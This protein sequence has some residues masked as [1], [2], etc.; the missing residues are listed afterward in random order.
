MTEQ[1]NFLL[2]EWACEEIDKWVK[3]F[4]EDRKRSAVLYALRIVQE[5]LGWLSEATMQAVGDYLEIPHIMVYE[6]ANFYSM[7]DLK[8]KGKHKL[9]VCTNI[10]CM[11]RG[12][13]AIADHLQQKLGIGF[14]QTTKDGK[15][16]LE[17]AECLA[18]CIGAPMMMVDD[19][20]YHENLTPERIDNI[21]AA[22]ETADGQ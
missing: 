11:L 7:Y 8:P 20:H 1:A 22:L 12:S 3:K 18:A 13:D 14:H 19:K 15:Y 2:S 16:T 5:D 4:P 10:S 9:S 6:V 17:E 21:L